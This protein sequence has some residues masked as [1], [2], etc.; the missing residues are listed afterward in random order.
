MSPFPVLRMLALA[1]MAVTSC[2]SLAPLR[3]P[4]LTDE[5]F[6]SGLPPV[7]LDGA[8]TATNGEGSL[9]IA[10]S[11]PGDLITDLERAGALSSSDV[12]YEQTFLPPA[13]SPPAP[14]APRGR[15]ISDNDTWTF[16]LSF[17]TP[18][19]QAELAALADVSL[20]FDGVKMAASVSLN[21][22]SVGAVAD[23][24]LRY[25][26]PVKSLLAAGSPN[27]LSLTFPTSNDDANAEGRWDSC[28]GGWVRRHALEANAECGSRRFSAATC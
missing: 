5:P 4:T 12:L 26:F 21:G 15:P 6:V 23:M 13:G 14:G 28:S 18:W 19:T 20:V 22:A 25:S 8:W 24:F 11:V 2:C 17:E 7:Y 1:T 9:L 27:T 3:A 10:G 16:S